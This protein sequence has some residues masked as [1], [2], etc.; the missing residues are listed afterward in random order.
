M[1]R[2]ETITG[3]TLR[4]I[5]RDRQDHFAQRDTILFK[6]YWFSLEG[7]IHII[8]LMEPHIKLNGI[9]DDKQSNYENIFIYIYI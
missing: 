6:R 5:L 3:F 4:P 7:V 2:D 8:N 1:K 9:K